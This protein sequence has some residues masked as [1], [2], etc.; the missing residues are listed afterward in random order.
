MIYGE[1]SAS[2]LS[3]EARNATVGDSSFGP[4]HT[5][6]GLPVPA[7][8]RAPSRFPSYLSFRHS[9][10]LVESPF[11]RRDT[12]RTITIP[13]SRFRE[14]TNLPCRFVRREQDDAPCHEIKLARAFELI[15]IESRRKYFQT[16]QREREGTHVWTLSRGSSLTPLLSPDNR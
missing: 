3:D 13:K 6:A 12:V 5:A 8:S 4:P 10:G 15:T 9:L 1:S 16:S 14:R 7:V 2:R 11:S